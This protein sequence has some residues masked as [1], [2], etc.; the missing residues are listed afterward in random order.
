MFRFTRAQRVVGCATLRFFCFET[1]VHFSR[2]L[3]LSFQSLGGDPR[4]LRG[5]FCMR[6][7]GTTRGHFARFAHTHGFQGFGFVLC[8]PGLRNTCIIFGLRTLLRDGRHA[9]IGHDL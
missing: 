6:L 2:C 3:V 4:S 8:K 9:A 1:S 5:C 7:R